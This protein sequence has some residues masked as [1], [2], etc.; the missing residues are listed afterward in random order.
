MF[1][2]QNDKTKVMTAKSAEMYV[3][4]K[5]TAPVNSLEPKVISILLETSGLAA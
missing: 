3:I 5:E 2:D 1:S 4:P